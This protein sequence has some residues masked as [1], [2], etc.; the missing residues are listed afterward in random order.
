M[1]ND[2]STFQ[3]D[4]NGVITN[5]S[6]LFMGSYTFIISVSDTSGNVINATFTVRVMIDDIAPYFIEVP[7]NID[8]IEGYP[9]EYDVEADDNVAIDHYWISD[10]GNF[11]IDG[12]GIITNNNGTVNWLEGNIDQDPLFLN[13]DEDDF[14]LTENSPCIDTGDPH[15]PPDPDG[16]RADMGAFYFHHTPGAEV[17]ADFFADSTTVN[18]YF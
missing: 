10:T 8:V 9:F 12:A 17:Y 2:T 6:Q 7:S 4:G 16:T 14:H 15:Y 5:N 13:P 1:L 18:I 11:S 3:I